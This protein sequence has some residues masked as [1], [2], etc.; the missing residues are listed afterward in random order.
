MYHEMFTMK[1]LRHRLNQGET[2][3]GCWV[4]LGSPTSAEIVG[5]TGFDWVLIDME[6]GLVDEQAALGIM[7]AL[8]ATP[9]GSVIRV[10]SANPQLV[11]RI[12]DMGAEGLMFP[13]LTDAAQ[14]CEAI[15]AMRFQPEGKRGVAKFIRATGFG[16]YF[17]D[18]LA[19]AKERLL[20]VIQIENE[21][22][23]NHLDEIAAADGVDVLF[24]G[25]SDLSMAMGIFR[26]FDHPKFRKAI[27]DTAAAAKKH[28]KAAGALLGSPADL[29]MYSE[30]GYRFLAFGND[31]GFVAAGAKAALD[32]LRK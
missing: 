31:C 30:L 15:S 1:Q 3:L 13:R 18:Y 4:G 23:L 22:V 27:A 20:G 25:P 10:L 21:E 6:H 14:A 9:A 16:A 8:E 7:Q 29:A 5:N 12:L 11:Q 19:H 17:D 26:Q 28:G 24:I 2:L 32:A